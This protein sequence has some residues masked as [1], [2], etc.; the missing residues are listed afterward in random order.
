MK[1]LCLVTIVLIFSPLKCQISLKTLDSAKM[2]SQLEA[3]SLESQVL[4]EELSHLLDRIEVNQDLVANQEILHEIVDRIQEI[5]EATEEDNFIKLSETVKH[6]RKEE[7]QLHESI[8]NLENLQSELEGINVIEK[9]NQ[10]VQ[11]MM[12]HRSLE[13]VDD[14]DESAVDED[15]TSEKLVQVKENMEQFVKLFR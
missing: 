14:N 15:D 5:G 13:E 8:N 1:S 2:I 7:E 6:K 12:T 10:K 4:A 9:V 11:E 3:A